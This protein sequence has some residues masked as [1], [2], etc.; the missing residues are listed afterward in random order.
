M[1][2]LVVHDNADLLLKSYD[3]VVSRTAAEQSTTFN[4]H[5]LEILAFHFTFETNL[6]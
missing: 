3:V 5:P 2:N 1:V 6:I 4:A